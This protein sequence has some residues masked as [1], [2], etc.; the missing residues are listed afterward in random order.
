MGD[1]DAITIRAFTENDAARAGVL[2]E[3][4]PYKVAQRLIHK[5]DQDRLNAF[6]LARLRK[7]AAAGQR[8]WIGEENGKVIALAGLSDDAWHSEIYG[9]KMGKIT[10]WMNTISS[11]AGERL[12]QEVLDS[13]A[14][15][16]FA[17]LSVRLDGEDFPNVHL[18]EAAN[19]RLIDVS[20]K[21]S[22]PMGTR[23]PDFESRREGWSVRLAGDGDAE[24][25]RRLGARSH[26]NNHFLN[27]PDLPAERT[28]ALFEA[29]VGR[30]IGGLAYR[31]YVL[32]D[33]SGVGRGFVTYL[34]N[35]TFTEAV[36]RNPII[37]DYVVIDPDIRGG[38]LGPWFIDESLARESES[39]FDYCELRTSQ[40]NHAAINCYE[41]LAFRL[42]ATDF[43]LH[44]RL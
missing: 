38:G 42:C 8:R 2:F 41:K 36:G 23:S 39:G 29:W 35:R 26:P 27:D 32:E 40:H 28:R 37:L 13:A 4:Y 6:Y 7:G 34:R 31:I 5:L 9:I 16:D 15:G 44:R 1:R 25:M 11:P 3:R 30:C 22:R 33:A 14:A 20:M 17:H 18:F 12:L 24:W 43:V 21:F 19:F 10:P